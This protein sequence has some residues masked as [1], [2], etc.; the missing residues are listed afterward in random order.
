MERIARAADPS[1]PRSWY[2]SSRC[3]VTTGIILTMPGIPMLFMGQEF[4]EDKQWSDDLDNHA[5]LRLYWEGLESNDPT[6]RDFLRFTRD[7]V[8]LRWR[9]PALRGEGY[10]LIHVDDQDR[11]LAFQR[12]V[13]GEGGDVI[14][15][16]SLA[17]ETKYNYRFGFPHGGHWREVF[18]SDVYERWVNPH[19]SGNGG[20]VTADGYGMHNLAYSASLT[21]PA[22]SILVFAR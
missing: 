20:G 17:N 21:L 12:W 11:V 14:V 4:M 15:I 8:N 3:R 22:N 19:V 10:A 1:N 13:P 16:V 2:A 5:N 6:M 18:N 9:F 7:L